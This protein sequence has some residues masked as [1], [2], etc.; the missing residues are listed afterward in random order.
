MGGKIVTW[1]AKSQAQ[2]AEIDREIA[3]SILHAIDNYLTTGAGDV[4]KL[5]P[6]R[7]ELRLRVGDYRV[8]FLVRGPRYIEVLAVKHRREAYR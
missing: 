5:R 7:E 3:L 1:S 4:K 2:L 6:P 8:F